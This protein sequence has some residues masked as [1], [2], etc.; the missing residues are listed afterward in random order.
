MDDKS[1]TIDQMESAYLDHMEQDY[2][3]G[4]EGYGYLPP[5]KRTLVCK[6][7]HVFLRENDGKPHRCEGSKP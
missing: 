6:C 1:P 3:L 7:G 5:R 2:G 4:G